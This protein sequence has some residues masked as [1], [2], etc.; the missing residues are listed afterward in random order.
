MLFY[1]LSNAFENP[2]LKNTLR[3]VG[4]LLREDNREIPRGNTNLR[5]H[6][7]YN[8]HNSIIGNIRIVSRED[9]HIFLVIFIIINY[10]YYKNISRR[11][12]RWQT[13]RKMASRDCVSFR[14]SM[15]TTYAVIT[16]YIHFVIGLP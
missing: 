15:H 13:N 6:K 16:L 3:L 12:V 5:V 10:Y 4:V 14:M 2:I 8:R 11:N 7:S 1:F 9:N